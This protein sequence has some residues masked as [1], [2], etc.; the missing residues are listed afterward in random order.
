MEAMPVM[1]IWVLKESEEKD[2]VTQYNRLLCININI[3]SYT[4]LRI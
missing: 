1:V 4:K 3:Q 2:T